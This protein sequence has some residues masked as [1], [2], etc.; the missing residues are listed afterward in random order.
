[1]PGKNNKLL[2][3]EISVSWDNISQQL[4]EENLDFSM[5]SILIFLAVD[6]VIFMLLALYVDA[7]NPGEY[8]LAKPWHFPVSVS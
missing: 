2:F 3:T 8:G 4:S 6:A 7:I 5:L 1:M